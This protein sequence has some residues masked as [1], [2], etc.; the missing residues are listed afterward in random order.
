IEDMIARSHNVDTSTQYFVSHL[1]YHARALCGILDVGNNEFGLVFFFEP[2][3]RRSE[4]LP[5][6]FP[7]HI[8]DN[9]DLHYASQNILPAPHLFSALSREAADS[10]QYL[11]QNAQETAK[12]SFNISPSRVA[13]FLI[14][15][16]NPVLGAS[17][18]RCAG[19]N[20]VV[21]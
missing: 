8:P 19:K 5:S 2:L 16:Y 6:G 9:Y 15:E 7:N 13:R 14:I 20:R 1:R 21:I 18:F 3:Q 11:S 17:V 4:N 12:K 10:I